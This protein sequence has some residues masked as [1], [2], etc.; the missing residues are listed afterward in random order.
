[1]RTDWE[2]II[3]ECK[4][5]C[6]KSLND[7]TNKMLV[8]DDPIKYEYSKHLPKTKVYGENGITCI[9]FNNK[10]SDA[11]KSYKEYFEK[12][13][14]GANPY[15]EFHDWGQP[16]RKELLLWVITA[17]TAMMYLNNIFGKDTVRVESFKM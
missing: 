17:E 6:Y 14:N 2:N 3:R 10:D 16:N 9:I 5:L 7:A 12:T 13:H 8:E 4:S 15:E 1:M 11:Y